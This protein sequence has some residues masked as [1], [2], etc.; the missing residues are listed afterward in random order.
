MENQWI[1]KK[2]KEQNSQWQS[3][4]W[5]HMDEHIVINHSYTPFNIKNKAVNI[6]FNLMLKERMVQIDIKTASKGDISRNPFYRICHV[7]MSSCFQRLWDI[8]SEINMNDLQD[9]RHKHENSL[10]PKPLIT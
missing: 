2:P 7:Q 5:I 8:L 4:G 10:I 6:Y 9:K 1:W 3:Q